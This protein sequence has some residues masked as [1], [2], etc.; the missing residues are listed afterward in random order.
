MTINHAGNLSEEYF[1]AYM[2]L[3]MNACQYNVDRAKEYTFQRLFGLEKESMGE[4]SYRNF[5]NAYDELKGM[6]E[7]H[8]FRFE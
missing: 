8:S 7:K 6:N 4:I 3:I 1:V 2:K 5:L